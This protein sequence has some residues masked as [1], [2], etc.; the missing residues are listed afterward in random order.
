V[1]VKTVYIAGPMRGYPLY[2]FPA[3]DAAKSQLERDGYRV[4]SPASMDRAA[5]FDP[6]THEATPQFI[7]SALMRDFSAIIQADEICLLTGW[8]QSQGTA[9]ELAFAKMIGRP[10][11]E[12]ETGKQLQNQTICEEANVLTQQDRNADYGHPKDN[13]EHT[14][15]LWRAMFGWD[16]QWYDVAR[17]MVLAKLSRQR[18]KPKR[19]N[20]TDIAGY[21]QCEQMGWE[22]PS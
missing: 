13:F 1:Q 7:E 14:A 12:L 8:R 19:D 16:C 18:N 5:G 10:A 15:G 11:W 21:A 2:N 17:A 6:A 9:L 4:L 22:K 20:L 3:F